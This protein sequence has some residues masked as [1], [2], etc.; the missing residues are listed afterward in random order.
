[1]LSNYFNSSYL[2]NLLLASY[3]GR[4]VVAASFFSIIAYYFTCY[5]RPVFYLVKRTEVA[6][7]ELSKIVCSMSGV[8]GRRMHDRNAKYYGH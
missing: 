7:C 8:V 6:D 2:P 3:Y 4:V 5:G 1:V